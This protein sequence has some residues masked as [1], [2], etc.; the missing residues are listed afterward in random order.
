MYK[1]QIKNV[2][3]LPD[4]NGE[5]ARQLGLLVKKENLGFGLRSWRYAMLV[6]D[7]TVEL[8]SIEPNLS[9]N[10]E[11]DPYEKSKPEVFLQEVR[12]HFGLNFINNEDEDK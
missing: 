11:T 6:S 1:R 7:G 5:L 3:P 10:C 12:D 8:M 9:D 4:G 2:K